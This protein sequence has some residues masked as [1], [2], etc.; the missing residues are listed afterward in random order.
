MGDMTITKES[1]T[2]EAINQFGQVRRTMTI[3]P[4]EG[5]W[6]KQQRG[7]EET[8]AEIEVEVQKKA[9]MQKDMFNSASEPEITCDGMGD[10]LANNTCDGFEGAQVKGMLSMSVSYVEHFTESSPVQKA[11]QA[12]IASLAGVDEV[13]DVTV[14]LSPSRPTFATTF[15]RLANA[16]AEVNFSIEVPAEENIATVASVLSQYDVEAVALYVD[17]FPAKDSSAEVS[18]STQFGALS[19][20]V[21]VLVTLLFF[22]VLVMGAVSFSSMKVGKRGGL[23]YTRSAP[24]VDDSASD[25]EVDL[26]SSDAEKL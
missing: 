17:G 26:S 5:W 7:K 12:A 3:K 21:W 15:R 16:I 25:R 1:A 14:T 4:K 2:I 9:Y 10:L 24:V 11:V 20:W 23:T 13:M 19:S 6:Q 22:G 18:S 8:V